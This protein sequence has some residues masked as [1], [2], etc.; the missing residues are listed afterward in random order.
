MSNPSDGGE[1]L[2]KQLPVDRLTSQRVVRRTDNLPQL[3]KSLNE[4]GLRV[5]IVVT[6]GLVVI[7]G[8]RR[9]QAAKNLGWTHIDCLVTNDYLRILDGVAAARP[10][11][12]GAADMFRM[13]E[14]YREIKPQSIIWQQTMRMPYR[15]GAAQGTKFPE[16]REAKILPRQIFLQK[17]VGNMPRWE[18]TSWLSVTETL[19][20]F[21]QRGPEYLAISS[22]I[23]ER[24][25][26]GITTINVVYEMLRNLTKNVSPA[27]VPETM[28]RW[29][30]RVDAAYEMSQQ[31][32]TDPDRVR[33]FRVRSKA[34]RKAESMQELKTDAAVQSLVATLAI[35]EG[36]VRDLNRVTVNTGVNAVLQASAA[37]HARRVRYMIGQFLKNN[38]PAPKD[39]RGNKSHEEK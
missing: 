7:D 22:A 12:T 34:R 27:Q 11:Y 29:Y 14:L 6:T 38:Y 9:L 1:D 8:L 30:E 13:V 23:T 36:M 20:E 4:D 32:L 5:P 26:N 33:R 15:V 2:L 17:L 37:Q 31:R 18:F 16:E 25:L 19:K 24:L 35:M 28:K 3:E 10:G 39:K 21:T